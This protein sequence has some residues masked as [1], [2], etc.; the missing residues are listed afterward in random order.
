MKKIIIIFSF[1]LS[2]FLIQAASAEI[3]LGQTKAVY[4]VGD[5]LALYI[6]LKPAVNTDSFLHMTLYCGNSSELIMHV[7]LLLSGGQQR[8]IQSNI[9]LTQEFLNSMLG[10]CIID[11][12]YGSDAGQSQSFEISNNINV[13]LN[14]GKT[15]IKAGESLIITGIAK[16]NN[17]ENVNG[18]AE[19]N[20][21]D[22]NINMKSIVSNG[23]FSL[24]LSFHENFKSGSYIININIYEQDKN[25]ETSNQ[26]ET[27]T[28][29]NVAQVP[30]KIEVAV[31]ETTVS[32]GAN[33]SFKIFL[34]DQANQEIPG[35]A[36]V[37]VKDA[38]EDSIWKKIIKT[39]ELQVLAIQ[40]NSSAGYWRIEASSNNL[41]IKRLF[42]VGENQEADFEIINTTI[43]ITNVGNVP[44]RKALQIAIGDKVEIKQMDLD[45]GESAKYRLLAPDGLYS[46]SITDGSKTI[47]RG[48]VSLTGNV[49]GVE[50]ARNQTGITKYP[51]VWLFLVSVLGLFI[52]MT[53]E[54]IRKQ[55]LSF[56][57]PTGGNIKKVE[58]RKESREEFLN[59]TKTDAVN[60]G[61]N[62]K[63][64]YSLVLK[65]DRTDAA[66]L[67][68][69]IKNNNKL[70]S[71]TKDKIN[72][73]FRELEYKKAAVMES[74]DFILVI[75]SP[76]LTKTFNT[77]VLA[78][79]TAMEAKEKLLGLKDLDFGLGI[80]I[81]EIVSKIESEK[82]KFTPFGNTLTLA[83]KASD[84]ADKDILL[85]K[86]VHDKT[87]SEV[88][89]SKVIIEG[90]ELYKIDS[91]SSREKY[92]DF[93]SKFK[94]RQGKG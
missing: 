89:A 18:F 85:T 7:P 35:E 74:Q 16:K 39:D 67:S 91:I 27:S 37:L 60:L 64:E 81:G 72:R 42:Y 13:E 30:K 25:G 86:E 46:I 54:R 94:A 41:S 93:I 66:I 90:R 84:L 9:S 83:K 69:K 40:K 28:A 61:D 12:S 43:L 14:P 20:I 44:Y 3:I 6:T 65:G 15:Y 21:K 56:Y 73:I 49:V 88:K 38:Y 75:F 80:N 11:A 79:K 34:Y 23:K 59:R 52:F 19:L 47:T 36:N 10:N 77:G 31:T 76:V 92:T 82:L 45:L 22:A 63:A 50:D 33:I 32:P 2:L 24:N 68:L 1:V 29:I 17:Q 4:S 87:M 48:D 58:V 51:I 5:N 53:I 57:A 62:I 78:V 26:G 55:N 71:Q 8:N 70:S